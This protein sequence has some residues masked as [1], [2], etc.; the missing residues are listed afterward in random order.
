[1]KQDIFHEPTQQTERKHGELTLTRDD[2]ERIYPDAPANA[3][4]YRWPAVGLQWLASMEIPCVGRPR[5]V[6]MHTQRAR[7]VAGLPV[8]K[9]D[10]GY[11]LYLLDSWRFPDDDVYSERQQ[12]YIVETEREADSLATMGLYA[13]TWLGDTQAMKWA[14]WSALDGLPAVLWLPEHLAKMATAH[15]WRYRIVPTSAGKPIDWLRAKWAEFDG[16]RA[17]I[18]D[19]ALWM[20][21]Y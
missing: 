5:M 10:R 4:I 17:K 8:T 2:I 11:P 14:D 18:K 12:V 20:E 3:R 19:A 1:M 6:Y 13:T 9:P 21:L 16:D 15:L 7:W